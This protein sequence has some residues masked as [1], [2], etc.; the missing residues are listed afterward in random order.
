DCSQLYIDPELIELL[1]L[2]E[3]RCVFA[4]ESDLVLQEQAWSSAD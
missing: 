2:G 1:D 4:I 3:G